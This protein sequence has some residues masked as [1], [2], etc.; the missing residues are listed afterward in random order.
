MQF[1]IK[2]CVAHLHGCSTAN[3]LEICRTPFYKNTS[4]GL[5]L[6]FILFV[7]V[8]VIN[9]TYYWLVF[10]IYRPEF[11]DWLK[12]FLKVFFIWWYIFRNSFPNVCCNWSTC[13]I[14]ISNFSQ[15]NVLCNCRNSPP[16][17]FFKKDHLIY[18]RY[19]CEEEQLH[20]WWTNVME[21]FLFYT[22]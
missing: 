20:K 12:T 18:T 19:K 6:G 8:Q 4:R 22:F 15:T 14:F 7:L 5:V 2:L 21:I 3:L 16:Q 10:I 13:F 9:K 1:Q 17:V 11:V